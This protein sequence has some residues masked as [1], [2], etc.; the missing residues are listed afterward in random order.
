MLNEQSLPFQ[1]LFSRIS[2]IWYDAQYL[3]EEND[4][5]KIFSSNKIYHLRH[6]F[7]IL[8]QRN[9]TQSIIRDTVY[10]LSPHIIKLE[11]IQSGKLF[12]K[13]SCTFGCP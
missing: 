13:P 4:F 2:V 5:A 8:D 7:F 11:Y 9:G 3:Q 6:F 1:P 12:S 10:L